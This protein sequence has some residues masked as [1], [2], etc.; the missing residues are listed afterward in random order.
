M[1]ALGLIADT[2]QD[3]ELDV[4]GFISALTYALDGVKVGSIPTGEDNVTIGEAGALRADKIKY[5]FVLGVCEG[6][7]PLTVSGSSFFSDSDKRVLDKALGEKSLSADSSERADDELLN[8][9]N[10]I[11]VASHGL[12]ISAPVADIKGTKRS[13]SLAYK[14]VKAL[15]PSLSCTEEINAPVEDKIYTKSVALEHL[16]DKGELGDAIRRA[17]GQ[18]ATSESEL[19]IRV[20]QELDA[21]QAEDCFS[22]EDSQIS[23]E[24]IEEIFGKRLYLSD[25]K[26]SKFAK[27]QFSYYCSVVLG[28]KESDKI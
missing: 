20:R 10:S 16:S 12:V 14:R 11:A 5:A 7:F 13:P 8:F 21:S 1:Y 23:P 24:G 15:L 4:D 2:V 28:I 18:S 17:L 22:N 3:E 6:A 27:C 25:S 26:I 9:K 19:D